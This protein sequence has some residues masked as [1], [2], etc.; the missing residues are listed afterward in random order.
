MF[1]ENVA[2]R[3]REACIR[4]MSCQTIVPKQAHG[5]A[6]RRTFTS[7][8]G[9]EATHVVYSHYGDAQRGVRRAA[10]G[11]TL[12]LRLTKPIDS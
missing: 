5:E 7:V 3:S 12:M 6:S 1:P 10:D 4:G 8:N 11:R 9:H 2:R